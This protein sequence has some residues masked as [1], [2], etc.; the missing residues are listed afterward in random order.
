L[1]SPYGKPLE[2]QQFFTCQMFYSL[3]KIQVLP[4]EFWQTLGDA[5]ART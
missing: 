3:A 4:N 5:L 2:R 1:P